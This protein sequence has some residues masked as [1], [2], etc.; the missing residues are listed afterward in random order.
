MADEFGLE[1]PRV[2]GS[3]ARG[4]DRPGSDLDLLVSV[5]KGKG[6]FALLGFARAVEALLG[7]RVDVVSEGG[8]GDGHA[9]IRHEAVPV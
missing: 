7:V 5:P 6:L 2:F 1:N 4:D 8:L 3:V 9:R